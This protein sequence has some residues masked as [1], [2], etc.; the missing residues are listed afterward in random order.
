MRL[1]V[2]N[3]DWHHG[4][5]DWQSVSSS[6]SGHSVLNAD[7]HH[8]DEDVL[9]GVRGRRNIEIPTITIVSMGPGSWEIPSRLPLGH[10]AGGTA[11]GAREPM[12]DGIPPDLF[13]FDGL[14]ELVLEPVDDVLN[15]GTVLD[16]ARASLF[17]GQRRVK[18]LIDRARV[19]L[20]GDRFP[21][22]LC[23]GQ[24]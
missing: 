20:A 2:L 24:R 5:E 16:E 7:W 12:F 4:D 22:D 8:G 10:L 11:V 9:A 15:E 18:N 19:E 23:V 6:K 1:S 13:P 14:E 17:V 21:E 3:A